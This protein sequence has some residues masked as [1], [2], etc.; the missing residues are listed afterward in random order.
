MSR[1]RLYFDESGT[2]SCTRLD[3]APDRYLA[4]CGVI[5]EDNSYRQFQTEWEAMKHRFFESGDPDEPIILHRKEVM[6]RTGSFSVLEDAEVR[7]QFDNEFLR[8]V[9]QS[10]F[11][12][13]IVVI[14]KAHHQ[15]QYAA[16][17][18]PYNYC[19]VALLQRYCFWLGVNKGDVMG[20]AR[21]R[22]EDKQ[23]K[24]AYSALYSAGDWRQRS[25]FYQKHLTSKDIKL[26]PKSKNIAGLQLADLLAHP[27]K[28][29][30]ILHRAPKADVE[31]S[32]F[33]RQVANVF[34]TKIR[35]RFDG[36]VKGWGE[37]FI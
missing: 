21:G 6:S 23:L 16:P 36:Q 13:I 22:V 34:W 12:S 33:G 14:D 37:I 15:Y 20:E 31:E 29:R 26:A 28:Q 4:L 32:T 35:R 30:C 3:L 5:F 1:Y 18:N 8:V 11:T 9:R 7:D 10:N 27:A 17:M 19:L 2:H 24:A 25:E